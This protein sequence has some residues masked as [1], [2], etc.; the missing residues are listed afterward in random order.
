GSL[1]SAENPAQEVDLAQYTAGTTEHGLPK[2]RAR[3]D[4]TAGT[5]LPIRGQVDYRTQ[6]DAA[7]AAS[8][9]LA[10]RAEDLA[11]AAAFPSQDEEAWTPPAIEAQPL[12]VR[13][14]TDAEP[15]PEP[16]AD[17]EAW[18]PQSASTE[19]PG[20]PTRKPAGLPTRTPAA[21]PQA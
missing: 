4:N 13:R 7:A 15:E 1:G 2:R 11:G 21:P 20:L 12:T 10:P 6:D 18:T 3:E 8:I 19:T 14:R 16:V 9:P 5:G 17:E